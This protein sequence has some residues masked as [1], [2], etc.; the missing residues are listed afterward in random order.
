[1]HPLEAKPDISRKYPF[2][3]YLPERVVE[4]ALK[5]MGPMQVSHVT[6]VKSLT[7]SE[8][9]GWFVGCPLTARQ[10]MTLPQDFVLD[11]I[12]QTARLAQELGAEIVG[13][14]AF[15]SVV[16]DGGITIA[17]NVD[18]AVTTGNSFTI[19]TA[20]MGVVKASPMMGIDPAQA[21]VA[22]V[23]AAGSIGRTCARLLARQ[24]PVIHLVGL[25]RESMEQA[26]EEIEAESKA[27][28][29]IFTE[30]HEGIK[31]ADIVASATSAVSAIIHPKDIKPG[32]VVCD[33]ARPRDVSARV[34][35]ER[36]D[37][38]IIDG[39]VVAIPG[40]VDFHFN[41]GFPPK[42]AYACMSETMMLALDGR[43]ENFTLGKT[44]SVEQVEEISAL[45]KKHGFDLAGF[46]SFERAVTAETIQ[47]TRE[48]AERKGAAHG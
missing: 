11:K 37:V 28:V 25:N 15:T 1:M 18:I 32:A 35:K 46:R 5:Q 6:G 39:G 34:A 2:A 21:K 45:A 8:A 44:V 7:G 26:K 10:M 42:T 9:E 20:I 19:A 30:V 38:L 43:Y 36:D 12:I 24:V 16:G 23:G 17:K 41:F 13:L 48:N 31:D 29:K 14:G 47:R 3:K 40:D 22:V 4:F 27:E 33:V